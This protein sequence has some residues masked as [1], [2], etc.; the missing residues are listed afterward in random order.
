MRLEGFVDRIADRFEIAF[1]AIRFAGLTYAPPM[2]NELMGKVNPR[3]FRYR[4]HQVLLNFL[5]I[6]VTREIEAAGY[7]THVRINDH[8]EGQAIGSPQDDVGSLAG[9][10]GKGEDLFHGLRNFT[11][12]L[13]DEFAAGAHYR[14]GFIA[15]KTGGADVLLQLTRTRVGKRFSRRV[16]FVERRCDLVDALIGTLS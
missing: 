9:D 15:E 10:T 7:T 4:R 1:Q 6:V 13:I 16:F 5:G 12:E 14:F 3:L 8:S 2:P 11:L